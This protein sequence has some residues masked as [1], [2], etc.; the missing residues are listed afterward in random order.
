MPEYGGEE[1][2][3]MEER[4]TGIDKRTRL[5]LII[6]LCI[7]WAA[8]SEAPIWKYLSPM[9]AAA[10]TFVAIMAIA[11]GIYGLDRLNRKSRNISL[12]W[13]P[14]LYLVF[15]SAFVTL[16]PYLQR[17]TLNHG[18]DREDAL[19]V[20]L[21][22][23]KHHQYPYD[24]RTFLGNPP[25]PLPGAILLAAPFFTVGHIAWQN[26][27]WLALFFWFTAHFFRY[28]ATALVFLVIFLL[29][30]PSNLSDFVAGGDYLTNFF[31]MAIALELFVRSIDSSLLSSIPAAML[32]GLAFSS[33]SIYIVASVPLLALTLQRAT[34]SR[35]AI[36]F[37]IIFAMAIAITFPVFMPHP[38]TH[39]FQQIN[40]NPGKVR[41]I[42]LFLHPQWTLPLLGF[43]VISF[44]FFIR[45]DLQRLFLLLGLSSFVM[46]A[47]PIATLAFHM[48]KL[49]FE[50][51]Y[52]AIC[53]LPFSLW[54]LSLCE[55]APAPHSEHGTHTYS[56][57]TLILPEA[58]DGNG[59]A[60]MRE[61]IQPCSCSM[62]FKTIS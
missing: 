30:A 35:T 57:S 20:E 48:R 17:H 24:A 33:R 13:L 51:S 12:R 50:C 56:T 4:I 38:F 32:L 44:S 62:F 22:A 36:L 39:L 31:Y 52:L 21:V 8:C 1:K 37:A 3:V 29:A 19:R 43:A 6:S 58:H 61:F 28:R 25:T 59:H 55:R 15:V 46:L 7:G 16:Y 2:R 47:P 27:L 10:A 34:R 41:Y 26:L 60:A 23:I 54:A 9:K 11:I 5:L 42:P 49:P 45:M 40:E 18:S 14:L 53:V